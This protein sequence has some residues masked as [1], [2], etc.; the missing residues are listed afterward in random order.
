MRA[1]PVSREAGFLL[2]GEREKQS[3][4]PEGLLYGADAFG[5]PSVT[6]AARYGICDAGAFG[7][8]SGKLGVGLRPFGGL[9]G[10]FRPKAGM[11]GD[12]LPAQKRGWFAP[13]ARKHDF[14]LRAP[15]PAFRRVARAIEIADRDGG[16]DFEIIGNVEF[17]PCPGR[18][19]PTH[20]VDL[21]AQSYGLEAELAEGGSGVVE[22]EAIGLAAVGE[23]LLAEG[24]REGAGMLRP[25]LILLDQKAE[26]TIKFG[27]FR[28]GGDDEPPGLFAETG[29][30]PSGGFE[31]SFQLPGFNVPAIECA[32][33]P[34]AADH[35]EQLMVFMH[36][37]VWMRSDCERSR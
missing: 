20:S 21:E 33:A 1:K 8:G 24:N 32:R 16:A 18:I 31:K 29:G 6:F 3:R 11:S 4:R 17:R 2:L 28:A 9:G 10:R 35:F 25:G 12:G 23:S 19:E 22:P 34:A 27:L 26:Q 13:I 37:V 36:A 30:G 5:A 7:D 15:F 14:R